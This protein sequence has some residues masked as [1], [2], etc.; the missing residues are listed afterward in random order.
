MLDR[1]GAGAR[2]RRPLPRRRQGH[3]HRAR[4]PRVARRPA[5]APAR[6]AACCPSSS[7]TGTGPSG[8]SAPSPGSSRRRS[9]G[10]VRVVV[11][12][13]GS[14]AGGAGDRARR[15][16]R[17]GRAGGAAPQ[18]RLRPRRQRRVPA[19]ARQPRSP[20]T[21]G[22]SAWPRTTPSRRRTAWP[23]CST[24]VGERPR[25]GLACADF[26]DGATPVVDPYFG[27]ILAPA[28]VAEGWEPA[29]HPHGTLMLA[30]REV[31]DGGGPV[32]RALLRLLRGGRPRAAGDGGRLGDRPRSAAP[33]S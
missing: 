8:A 19:R 11:V 23:A 18:P 24:A 7:S 15:A 2:H 4:P 22:G 20:T 33:S 29:G 3:A 6:M 9:P 13:N 17:R 21:P 14:D 28:T 26:G 12:D 32:R 30:R 1:G 31:L 25:A 5:S 27:G 10:G 16:A